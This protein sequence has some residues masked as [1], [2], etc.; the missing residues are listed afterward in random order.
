MG[1]VTSATQKG[2]L[3]MT[4]IL[5][6]LAGCGVGCVVALVQGLCVLAGVLCVGFLGSCVL[7]WLFEALMGD[8]EQ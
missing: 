3:N 5:L 6:T 7:N 2:G 1:C 4:E 8:N